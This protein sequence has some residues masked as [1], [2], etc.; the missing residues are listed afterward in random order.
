[1][2]SSEFF[3]PK[4]SVKILRLQNF[5]FICHKH[6]NIYVTVFKSYFETCQFSK[7]FV[8]ILSLKHATISA[9]LLA[10]A[11]DVRAHRRCADHGL[12]ADMVHTALNSLVALDAPTLFL[13]WLTHATRG[14]CNSHRRN[15]FQ[16]FCNTAKHLSVFI[17][18]CFLLSSVPPHIW[19]NVFNFT[20]KMKWW[21]WHLHWFTT[22]FIVYH[23]EGSL[24]YQR[25]DYADSWN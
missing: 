2:G 21:S 12:T 4:Y 25:D 9:Y 13:Q 11:A 5:N 16:S 23:C 20:S 22:F 10:M 15:T 18:Q 17:I 7:H 24:K 14:W 19:E 1:M 8:L 3:F 6:W